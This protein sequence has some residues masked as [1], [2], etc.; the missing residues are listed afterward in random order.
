MCAGQFTRHL[1]GILRFNPFYSQMCI[2]VG[3]VP[4]SIATVLLDNIESNLQLKKCFENMY[5]I[6]FFRD[7]A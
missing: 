6:T 2:L 5:Q 1:F 7:L 3:T 4:D